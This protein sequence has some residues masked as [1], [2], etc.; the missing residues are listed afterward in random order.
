[1]NHDDQ[2]TQ[3]LGA[4]IESFDIPEDQFKVAEFACKAACDFLSTYWS[5]SGTGGALYPQGSMRLGTVTAL[6]HRHDEYDLDMVC[7]ARPREVADRSGGP[8]ADVGDARRRLHRSTLPD[9]R[10][11][12][13]N[14]SVWCHIHH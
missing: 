7:P 4:G 5:D 13:R 8:Q 10:I 14:R 11:S 9:H 1:M 12:Q 6:I 3:V 2:L